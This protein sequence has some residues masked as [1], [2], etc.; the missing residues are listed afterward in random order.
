MWHHQAFKGKGVIVTGAAA[1]IGEAVARRFAECSADVAVLDLN[2]AGAEEVAAQ[3]RLSGTRSF[4]VQASVTSEAELGAAVGECLARF[5]RVDILVNTAGGFPGRRDAVEMTEAEWDKT[6][7]LNLKSVFLCAKA[8]LPTMIDQRYGRIISVASE[9]GRSPVHLSTAA[10]AAAK[11]GVI[12]FTRHLAKEV[13]RY[14]ITVNAT[15]PGVTLSP[16]VKT[17]YD[18]ARIEEFKKMIP[19]GRVAEPLDQA[20]PILFLASD[21]ARHITGVT[22]DVNGGYLMV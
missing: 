11:A 21:A 9:A 17:I 5:G 13:G 7:A 4:A 3:L 14:G 19:L 2:L 16:R 1:G 6:V 10:Y 20:D 8:V 18:D 15:A 12:G 22:L